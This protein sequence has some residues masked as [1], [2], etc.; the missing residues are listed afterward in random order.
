MP[1]WEDDPDFDLDYH[2]D[3]LPLP[4][5][6]DRA[7]LEALVSEQRSKMLDHGRPL[8]RFHLIQGYEGTSAIHARVQHAIADG[9]ALVRLVM[10]LADEADG[11]AAVEVVDREPQERK[12]DSA[13][14]SWS[15]AVDLGKRAVESVADAAAA[16][17]GRGHRRGPQPVGHPRQAGLGRRRADRGAVPGA[18]PG[19]LPGVRV[20][21][22]PRRRVAEQ[23]EAGDRRGRSASPAAPATR[24]TS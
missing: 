10:S 13:L 11:R 23:L 15:R 14:A 1:H 5:P 21:Q 17:V 22:V 18:R 7:A 12:R 20:P 24:S 16:A 2:V 19:A 3:V 6:G 4:E 8:W 9:W